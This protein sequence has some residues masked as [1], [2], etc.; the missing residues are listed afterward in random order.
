MR[1]NIKTIQS[2]TSMTKM[3]LD[4]LLEGYFLVFKHILFDTFDQFVHISNHSFSYDQK[5]ELTRH[6]IFVEK[7]FLS[8]TRKPIFV[9]IST[10]DYISLCVVRF[11][12]FREKR[13]VG[14]NSLRYHCFKAVCNSL[15]PN[16]PHSENFISITFQMAKKFVRSS[17]FV[18]RCI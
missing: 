14:W 18:D 2:K 10:N 11:T 7:Y 13:N 9:M 17:I 15:I 6:K 3:A 12:L 16:S 5:F 4:Q 8:T 1:R